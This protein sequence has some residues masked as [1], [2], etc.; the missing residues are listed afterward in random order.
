MT[1][2]D[3]ACANTNYQHLFIRFII[4]MNHNSFS[5]KKLKYALHG[6]CGMTAGGYDQK[7]RLH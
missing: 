6:G 7:G 5:G 4:L 3:F 1:I 2:K